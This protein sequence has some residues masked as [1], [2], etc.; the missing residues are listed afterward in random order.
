MHWS[1]TQSIVRSELQVTCVSEQV[2]SEQPARILAFGPPRNGRSARVRR[3]RLRFGLWIR[4]YVHRSSVSFRNISRSFTLTSLS[5]QSLKRLTARGIIIAVQAILGTTGARSC[6]RRLNGSLARRR[7]GRSNAPRTL[8][9][10]RQR[11]QRRRNCDALLMAAVVVS[12]VAMFFNSASH[13]Q[14]PKDCIRSGRSSLPEAKVHG[15]A[16]SGVAS[17]DELRRGAAAGA[18]GV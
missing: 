16:R 14:F 15:V 11:W 13:F 12:G 4:R 18:R 6:L 7:G 17:A 5:F 10:L 8:Q 2:R 3:L 9:Q 1:Q